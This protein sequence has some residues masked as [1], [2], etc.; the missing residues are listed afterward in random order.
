MQVCAASRTILKTYER[1]M[2]SALRNKRWTT[3]NGHG[4]H[5][6]S[7][8]FLCQLPQKLLYQ[9]C[10]TISFS[11]PICAIS[12]AAWTM[13]YQIQILLVSRYLQHLTWMRRLY[14]ALNVQVNLLFSV[15]INFP[16]GVLY[17]INGQSPRQP[18]IYGSTLYLT[19]REIVQQ[20]Q[21]KAVSTELYNSNWVIQKLCWCIRFSSKRDCRVAFE[22]KDS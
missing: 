17:V 4:S 22:H 1:L 20:W 7:P 19:T 3:L 8:K 6:I 15:H 18:F 5:S 10:L 13:N 9:P 12:T 21:P 16:G 14:V 11:P 2:W